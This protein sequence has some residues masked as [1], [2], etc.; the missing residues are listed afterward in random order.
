MAKF[1][2]SFNKEALKKNLYFYSQML[3]VLFIFKIYSAQKILLKWITKIIIFK[4]IIQIQQLVKKLICIWCI[5]FES[6]P[7]RSLCGFWYKQNS[8]EPAPV[9]ICSC[10]IKLKSINA[11]LCFLNRKISPL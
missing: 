11:A 4:E 7:K 9:R 10:C 3:M 5:A 1:L 8:E 2:L 6:F